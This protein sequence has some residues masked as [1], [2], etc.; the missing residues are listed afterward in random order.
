MDKRFRTALSKCRF[1]PHHPFFQRLLA[2][3]L[4]MLQMNSKTYHLYEEYFSNELKY[5]ACYYEQGVPT[6]YITPHTSLHFEHHLS[7]DDRSTFHHASQA[8]VI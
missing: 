3:K 5:L 1:P 2:L 8:H 4:E 6:N 7:T